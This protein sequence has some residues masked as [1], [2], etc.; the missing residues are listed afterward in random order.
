MAKIVEK[1]QVQFIDGYFVCNGEIVHLP[2]NVCL[3]ALKLDLMVQEFRY[4]KAQPAFCPEPSL[5]GFVAQSMFSKLPKI[6]VAKIPTPAFDE[7]VVTAEKFMDE[8]DLIAD[9][10][11]V[12]KTIEQFGE[13]VK[14]S[15]SDYVVI[16]QY[17]GDIRVDTPVLGNL[18]ELGIDDVMGFINEICES[19]FSFALNR[20]DL[21]DGD[22][23]VT[24]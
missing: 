23:D 19:P 1:D 21:K 13:L 8:V 5:E 22:I 4:I 2:R 12:N 16:S 3:Q 7:A 11:K 20:D 18:L 6:D 17:D 15:D 10:K 9:A 24:A 14:F